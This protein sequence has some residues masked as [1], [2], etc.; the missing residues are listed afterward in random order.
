M[1][2]MVKK[3]KNSEAIINN[4][5]VLEKASN[6]NNSI[7]SMRYISIFGV[8]LVHCFP[9]SGYLLIIVNEFVRFAVP[10]F[11]VTS[12][13]FLAE[14]L[15]KGDNI[16]VYLKYV[17]RIFYLYLLWQ[18]VYFLKPGVHNILKYGLFE[19][20]IIKATNFLK[21]ATIESLIFNGFSYHLWFFPSLIMTVLLFVFFKL[22]NIKIGLII[23]GFLYIIGVIAGSYASTPIGIRLPFHTRNFVFFSAL[24]FFLG[25]YLSICNKKTNL[26]YS[27]IIL[28]IG[29]IG[30]FTE[31]YFLNKY[32]NIYIGDFGFSTF[33]MGLGAFLIA[34]VR[35]GI[36]EN[37]KFAKLG[38][39]SLGIYGCHLLV[40][41]YIKFLNSGFLFPI[42]FVI[43]P[44]LVLI[45][46]TII[47]Y[48][49]NKYNLLK[50]LYK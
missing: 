10:F 5:I 40:A 36:L 33:L 39:L 27:L 21:N 29:F 8:I 37:E 46:S 28:F 48:I 19:E 24:P 23:S 7:D 41:N 12:G 34:K 43:Y 15:K 9:A 45:I 16:W 2:Q 22:K 1:L 14:K 4:G 6:R 38:K 25:A 47:I 35:V 30:H 11:F 26:P 20:Y 42:W 3:I 44:T 18:L 49:L 13:Y 17:K 31:G 32:F 50:V